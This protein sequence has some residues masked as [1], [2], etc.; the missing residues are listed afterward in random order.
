LLLVTTASFFV[1]LQAKGTI[2]D[3]LKKQGLTGFDS[4]EVGV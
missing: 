2:F 1:S 3:I 4:K